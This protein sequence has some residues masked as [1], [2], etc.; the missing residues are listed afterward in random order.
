M[1]GQ[2]TQLIPDRSG[3]RSTEPNVPQRT[4]SYPFVSVVVLTLARPELLRKC[5]ESLRVPDYQHDRYEVIVV[6]DGTQDGEAI[7]A[8]MAPTFS[9]PIRYIHIPYTGAA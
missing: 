1:G 3:N 6:E 7:V 4:G 2:V 8:Q 9:V 5:L